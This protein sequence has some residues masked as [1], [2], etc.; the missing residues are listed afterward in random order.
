GRGMSSGCPKSVPNKGVQPTAYSLR[1]AALCSGFR[2]RLTPSVRLK[3]FEEG[4]YLCPNRVKPRTTI[5]SSLPSRQTLRFG[6]ATMRGT[7][8][9]RKLEPFQ[10]VYCRVCTSLNSV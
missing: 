7:S 9:R 10:A 2:Q 3:D 6:L 1:Y 8:C 4:V 5:S